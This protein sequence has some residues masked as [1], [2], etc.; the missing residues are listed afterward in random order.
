V[1]NAILFVPVAKPPE[2]TN[3][4]CPAALPEAEKGIVIAN[5]EILKIRNGI[6]FQHGKRSK[7]CTAK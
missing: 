6:S 2:R 5:A 7:E 4:P 3:N 1:E